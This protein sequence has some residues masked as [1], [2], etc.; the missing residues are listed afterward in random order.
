MLPPNL[1]TAIGRP[2]AALVGEVAGLAQAMRRRQLNQLSGSWAMLPGG[3][4]AA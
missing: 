2:G 3:V 4:N 1:A